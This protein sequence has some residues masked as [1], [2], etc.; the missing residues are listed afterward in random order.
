MLDQKRYS[1][2]ELGLF[3]PAYTGFIL[4]ASICQFVSFKQVF[5]C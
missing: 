4:N 1:E 2:E 5:R 3:N